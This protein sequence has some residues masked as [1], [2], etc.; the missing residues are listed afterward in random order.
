MTGHA[1][2]LS[3]SPAISFRKRSIAAALSGEHR[4]VHV[5]V[6]DLGAVLPPAGAPPSAS[7]KRPSRI[8]RLKGLL[9]VTLV[10]SPMLTNGRPSPMP[11]G[12]RPKAA[13]AAGISS[14]RVG[15]GGP[16]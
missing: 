11:T 7:S 6:D 1:R 8:I 5:D 16:S 14:R 4:L 9:P 12:S 13:S 15:H 2:D 10:R 3:G